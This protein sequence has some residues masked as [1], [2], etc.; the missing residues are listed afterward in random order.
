MKMYVVTT[1]FR[2]YESLFTKKTKKNKETSQYGT[3]TYV[4]PVYDCLNE[5]IEE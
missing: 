2:N 1:N 5:H 3:G 4:V